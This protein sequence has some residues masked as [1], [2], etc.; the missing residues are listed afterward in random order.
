MTAAVVFARASIAHHS[1]SFA[2]ASRLLPPRCRDEASIL[3]AWCRR[4][5][6]AIDL[7]PPAE[8]P[9]AAARLSAELDAMQRGDSL[10]PILA[11]TA[12]VVRARAIPFAYL[13]ELVAGMEMDARGD[14]YESLEDLRHY[15]FRV[16]GTV[17]LMMSHVMQVG[18]AGALPNAVHLGIA[19][20]LTNICRDVAEDWGRG[21]LYLPLSMLREEGV[22]ASAIDRDRAAIS[23]VVRRLLLEAE[24]HYASADLGVDALP[25][26][27]ALA[28]RAAR[29]VYAAIGARLLRAGCDPFRG[30]AVVPMR[31][32]L[33]LV[34][35]ALASTL[36]SLSS[37][38]RRPR[39]AAALPLLRFPH[40]VPALGV[41]A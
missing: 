36:G 9:E 26:R 29:N 4:A 39:V 18:S 19:M 41:N 33:W 5:D 13:R 12:E 28:V 11:A 31:G 16:A 35:R 20:Q 25:F 7:A 14:R 8:Q 27:C 2:L 21:R 38:P 22:D 32:K 24:R 6:D 15:C 17:G 3:Y 10:E 40:D 37:R 1:K 34:A 23:R 30:R